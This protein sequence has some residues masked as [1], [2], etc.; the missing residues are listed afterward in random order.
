MRSSRASI[1]RISPPPKL[2]LKLQRLPRKKPRARLRL[3][4]RRVRP[5]LRRL[6][7]L[8]LCLLPL[9]LRLPLALWLRRRLLLP[10]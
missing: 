5:H 3:L 10:V 7:A 8:R 4:L 9:L 6:R 2:L 1:S